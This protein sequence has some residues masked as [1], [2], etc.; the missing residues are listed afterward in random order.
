[1]KVKIRRGRLRSEESAKEKE[2]AERLEQTETDLAVPPVR[3]GLEELYSSIRQDFG[4]M[5]RLNIYLGEDI[6]Q[7][8]QRERLRRELR[9]CGTGDWQAK[10]YVI[11]HIKEL[12]LRKY[13]MTEEWIEQLYPLDNGRNCFAAML[14]RCRKRYGKKALE[15]L[16][17]LLGLV[18][19]ERID[20]TQIL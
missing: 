4:E 12:L 6:S 18:D 5:L 14:F 15:E 13:H 19:R 1:M 3:M 8:R 17:P 7:I 10:A 20:E 11:G 9:K 16:F 2:R